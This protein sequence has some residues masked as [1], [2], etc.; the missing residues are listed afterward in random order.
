M[1]PADADAADADA[2]DAGTVL[3]ELSPLVETVRSCTLHPSPR[4]HD[5]PSDRQRLNDGRAPR[6]ESR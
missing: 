4:A 2:A 5:L 1:W 3:N 6:F